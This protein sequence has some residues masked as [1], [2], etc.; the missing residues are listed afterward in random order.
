M[1]IRMKDIAKELGISVVT[2]SKVVNN[3][4]D[5]SPSTRER[6]LR[7][8]KELNYQPSMHAQGLAFGRTLM[9]GF[10]V[11]DL[12]HAFF[13]EVAQSI[14][15]VIRKKGYCLLVASSEEEPELEDRE[16]QQMILRRVDVLIVASCQTESATLRSVAQQKVP[17]ILIDR[18]L[19][20]FD[21]HFVGTDDVLVGKLAT[22]HLIALGR[23][24]IAHIGGH[25]V[26]TSNERLEGYKRALA[27]HKIPFAA[28]YVIPR[29]LGD[30]A[31]DESGKLAMEKLLM[32]KPRPDGVFCYNDPAAIGAMNAILAAGLRIPEDIA[33]VGSGNIR[34]AESLRVPLS[35]VDVP[36]KSLGE[37][38]GE[39]ALELTGTQKK[40]RNK[41]IIIQ[42]KLIV[43]DSTR[44]T[45]SSGAPNTK[46]QRAVLRRGTEVR[47]AR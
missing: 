18:S 43:R 12:V 19:S 44:G 24:R 22:E 41:R 25:K 33:V 47:S 45:P 38:A 14:S 13:S 27:R 9:V 16:I 2:V 1:T 21:A 37:T 39:L 17:L 31:G 23:R 42:P 20:K 26:S 28:K 29:A 4:S 36:C 32:L 35:S 8:I 10:V 3:H 5:I 15:G 30:R 40:S 34:Y 46:P 11:P 7:R 6:V